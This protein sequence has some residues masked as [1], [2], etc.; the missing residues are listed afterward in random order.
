MRA[1]I[2]GVELEKSDLSES[3]NL[4]VEQLCDTDALF[5]AKIDPALKE[6]AEKQCPYLVKELKYFD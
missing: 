1:N 4:A 6:A 5:E 3:K 2:H